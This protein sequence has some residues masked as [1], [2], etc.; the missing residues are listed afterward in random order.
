M[1]K[2]IL[3]PVDGSA[4]AM[5]AIEF[6]SHLASQEDA[7]IHLLHVYKNAQIPEGVRD[8]I[9]AE[10]IKESPSVIYLQT[11]GNDIIDTARN[12]AK[13]HGVKEIETFVISGDTADEILNYARV[14]YIDMIVLGSRGLGSTSRRVC[15]ESYRTCVIVR[16]TFLDGKSILVI[17]DEPDVLETV[18]ELLDMCDVKTASTFE[19]A[20]DLL[21]TKHFDMAILDVMGVNGYELLNI[22][23]RR[24]VVAVML[25]AHA[26]TLEDTIRSY[27]EGAASFIP[28]E[29]M[30][31]LP[32]F[33]NDI[34]EAKEKGKHFWW[35]WFDRFGS[36]YEKRFGTKN[37]LS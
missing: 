21:E 4:H 23:N 17:D 19:K 29:K 25:T 18:G 32:T 31:N 10:R 28:K 2:K 20:K 26:M 9:K 3:V 30:T 37:P 6:A 13:K 1:L 8:Y 36:Y 33:L 12:E 24:K 22:A 7:E 14:Y 5:K 35:R 16:K 11:V 27:K 15:Q 34:L